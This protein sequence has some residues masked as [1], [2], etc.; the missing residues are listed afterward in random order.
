ME[1]REEFESRAL[2][3]KEGETLLLYSPPSKNRWG[4]TCS[5]TA[6]LPQ[7]RCCGFGCLRQEEPLKKS[8][9]SSGTTAR[10]GGS[11]A[12]A[13]LVLPQRFS[14]GG[15]YKRRV[16]PSFVFKALAQVSTLSSINEPKLKLPRSPTPLPQ[17]C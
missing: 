7:C 12:A 13:E 15:E 11:T 17:L 14:E 4:S 5:A 1:E 2:K 10:S 9:E 8:E 3:T 16:S 6:V